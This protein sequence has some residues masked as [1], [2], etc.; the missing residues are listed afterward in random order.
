MDQN[1]TRSRCT[2]SEASQ[3]M[4]LAKNSISTIGTKILLCK[5]TN[6][7]QDSGVK[8]RNNKL[9]ELT[10]Q[11]KFS[12]IPELESQNNVQKRTQM[13]MPAGQLSS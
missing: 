6:V 5:C 11:C 4:N 9:G 3:V 10:V 2:P 7:Y 1:F 13:G 12:S 8:Y